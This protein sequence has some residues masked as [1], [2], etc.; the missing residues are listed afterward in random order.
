[1]VNQLLSKTKNIFDLCDRLKNLVRRGFGC[2]AYQDRRTAYI[3]VDDETL[4]HP[5]G[6]KRTGEE[7]C[8]TS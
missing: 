2:I 6:I 5:Q 4:K 1:M 7:W 3:F 8:T